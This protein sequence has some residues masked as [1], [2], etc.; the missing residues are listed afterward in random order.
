[1][2]NT[3]VLKNCNSSHRQMC[4]MPGRLHNHYNRTITKVGKLTLKSRKSCCHNS[5]ATQAHL[6]KIDVVR[7]QMARMLA[8]L[9]IHACKQE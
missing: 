1:M 6:C 9:I 8:V 3:E 5:S 4:L 7:G 2:L